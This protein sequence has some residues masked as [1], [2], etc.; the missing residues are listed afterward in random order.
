MAEE[1]RAIQ[2]IA[3]FLIACLL[4]YGLVY[5]FQK[6]AWEETA[7]SDG[8]TAGQAV[9]P[10]VTKPVPVDITVTPS[11]NQFNHSATVSSAG[12]VTT[13]TDTSCTV[14]VEN[15]GDDTILDYT[16]TLYNP[17]TAEYGLP[18]ALETT[19]HEI[20]AV[21]GA[22]YTPIFKDDDYKA[23][24]IIPSLV[25]GQVSSFNVTSRMKVAPDGA[26]KDGQTY[27]IELYLGQPHADYYVVEKLTLLT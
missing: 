22:T 5:Y 2:F 15:T 3:V 18:E 20:Y 1:R 23:G 27:T 25:A 16:A 24:F 10:V 6:P 26:F 13:Q 21:V 17:V 12:N 11:T 14:T 4:T 8:Y 19:Y 9:V 7:Y